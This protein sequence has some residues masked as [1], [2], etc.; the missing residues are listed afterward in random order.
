MSEAYLLSPHPIAGHHIA[1]PTLGIFEL[2]VCGIIE[3]AVEFGVAEDGLDHF[4]RVAEPDVV[5]RGL[6]FGWAGG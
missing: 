1:I 4:A 5:L 6:P 2:S 3:V